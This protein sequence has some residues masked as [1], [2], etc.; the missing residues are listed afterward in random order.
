MAL[1]H[2]PSI[3]LNDLS[4]YFDSNNTQKSWR[5]KPTTNLITNFNLITHG[6]G[7][8]TINNTYSLVSPNG[9]SGWSS[10]TNSGATSNYRVAQFPYITLTSG[11]TYTA[12]IELYNPNS[13]GLSVFMDGNAGLAPTNIPQGYSRWTHTFTATANWIENIFFGTFNNISAVTYSPSRTVFFKNPQIEVGSVASPFV[14]GTRPNNQSLFD[15]T[16]NNTITAN[17]LTYASDGTFSFNGTTDYAQCTNNCNLTGSITLTAWV[18]NFY[19]GSG[20]HKTVICT[21]ISFANGVK[22]MNYKNDH[23]WGLWLGFGA[24]NFE[25]FTNVNINDN[26]NKMLTGSWNRAT[27]VVKLYLNGVLTATINTGQTGQISLSGG[28]IT[29]GAEYHSLGNNGFGGNI[30][31][32]A[33]YNRVLSDTE[34]YNLFLANRTRY[35]L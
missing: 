3:A 9:T 4:F 29:L 18:K 27:G 10:I 34:V 32:A 33:I 15:L 20:P 25:A 5:G 26:T 14:N 28:Q 7:L 35:G 11:T 16:R 21:D 23:R 24:T 13:Q 8:S 12:S 31:S 6:D 30:Y 17:S 19:S 2:S 22:L 1:A